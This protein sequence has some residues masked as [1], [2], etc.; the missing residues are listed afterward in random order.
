MTVVIS[1]DTGESYLLDR[2]L[3]V[4]NV[5]DRVNAARGGGELIAFQNNDIPSR[6]FYVD[7]DH[8]VAI[9][10]DGHTY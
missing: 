6:V 9:K 4:A 8:V 3:Y 1:L 7:P 2:Q 10:D 5:A